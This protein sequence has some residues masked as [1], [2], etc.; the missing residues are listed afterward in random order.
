MYASGFG[1]SL[2]A[3]ASHQRPMT[4]LVLTASSAASAHPSQ[5]GGTSAIRGGKNMLP[6][7]VASVWLCLLVASLHFGFN[8]TAQSKPKAPG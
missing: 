6:T 3:A 1:V 2:S 5:G 7:L 8:G 4:A